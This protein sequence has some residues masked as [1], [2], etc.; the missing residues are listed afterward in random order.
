[1]HQGTRS[2][3]VLQTGAISCALVGHHL[4]PVVKVL[5]LGVYGPHRAYFPAEATSNAVV[6]NDENLHNIPCALIFR[7]ETPGIDKD[8]PEEEV[9]GLLY[10]LLVLRREAEH[11]HL[12]LALHEVHQFLVILAQVLMDGQRVFVDLKGAP[13]AQARPSLSVVILRRSGQGMDMGKGRG[14]AEIGR[15]PE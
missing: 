12:V 13:Y 2:R 7:H 8:R 14:E 9:Q 10:R 5:E 1:M 4:K 15:L 3:T 6:L 11:V